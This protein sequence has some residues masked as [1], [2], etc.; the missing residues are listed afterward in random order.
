MPQPTSRAKS[1]GR[2]GIETS[3]REKMTAV[4]AEARAPSEFAQATPAAP[5]DLTV[6]SVITTD[7]TAELAVTIGTKKVFLL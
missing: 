5:I 2:C 3:R 4:I 7:T 1:F 6:S